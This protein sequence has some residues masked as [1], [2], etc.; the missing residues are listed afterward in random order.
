VRVPSDD[1]RR[2]QDGSG[3]G[4]AGALPDFREVL[5]R[6]RE[7]ERSGVGTE[8]EP[9]PVAAPPP[10]YPGPM[11][12]AGAERPSQ[13]PALARALERI[14][15]IL[16]KEGGPPSV[17]LRLGLSLTVTLEQR[18]SGIELS[19]HAARGL[20][21]LA[22]KELPELVAA[23]RARQVRVARAGVYAGTRRRH[24]R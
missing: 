17:T 13:A 24:G 22:E 21:P 8:R 9:P 19:L 4:R 20:S 14:A 11:A 10:A 1:L 12:G 7:R 2:A 6:E 3:P 23:L 16:E 15:L 5:A 18:P